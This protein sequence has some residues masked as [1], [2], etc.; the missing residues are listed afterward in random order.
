M[1]EEE[2]LSVFLD[3]ISER[4]PEHLEQFE[5]EAKEMGVPIIRK[6]A[7]RFLKVMLAMKRPETVLEIGTG[8]GYSAVFM[9]EYAPSIKE[10][11]TVE[12]YEPRIKEAGERIRRADPEGIITLREGDAEEVLKT[13][14]ESYFDLV[15]LDAAKGQYPML[16]PEIHRV[17]KKGAVLLTDNVLFQDAVLESR[18]V[19]TRRDRT[20][21]KRMRAFLGTLMDERSFRSTVLT[22]ADGVALSIKL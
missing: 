15:F 19:V 1:T 16:L 3:S 14:P 13:L 4:P 8:I 11:V 12:N 7:Q 5:T 6:E 10:L 9:K 17:M 2:R 20:I 21:H 18:F 22:I